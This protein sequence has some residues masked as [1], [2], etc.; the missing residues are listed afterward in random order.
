[1][2]PD[3]LVA[4]LKE[5]I[6]LRRVALPKKRSRVWARGNSG[7]LIVLINLVHRDVII[8]R[9]LTENSIRAN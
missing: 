9:D 1:V 5:D 6:L 4:C 2:T 7:I 3:K 8:R